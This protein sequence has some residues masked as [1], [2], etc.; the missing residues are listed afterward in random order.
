MAVADDLEQ[1]RAALTMINPAP[2][3]A[4]APP[5]AL[6]ADITR[7]RTTTSAATSPYRRTTAAWRSAGPSET[8]PR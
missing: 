1:D 2:Y 7:S 5:E 3:N 4:E 6:S 8:R